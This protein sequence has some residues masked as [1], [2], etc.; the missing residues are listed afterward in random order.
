MKDFFIVC[1]LIAWIATGVWATALL[2]IGT[3]T[4]N[5]EL[6]SKGWQ[7]SIASMVFRLWVDF[8]QR[9]EP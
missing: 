7:F 1:H 5:E 8:E 6:M 2:A 3:F 9:S 4:L